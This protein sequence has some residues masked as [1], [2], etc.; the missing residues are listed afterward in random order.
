MYHGIIATDP[1]TGI[2]TVNVPA[3]DNALPSVDWWRLDV[4]LGSQRRTANYGPLSV[5]A[6]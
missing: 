1:T 6:V 5:V 4:L 3:A 2:V